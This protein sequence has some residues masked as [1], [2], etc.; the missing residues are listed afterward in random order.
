MPTVKLMEQRWFRIVSSAYCEAVLLFA[1]YFILPWFPS[2][3]AISVIVL[4]WSCVSVFSGLLSRSGR[5][6]IRFC[7]WD[8][9]RRKSRY[10]VRD[11]G[12]GRERMY[13][14]VICLG[15]ICWIHVF[16]FAFPIVIIYSLVYYDSLGDECSMSTFWFKV[17]TLV[18]RYFLST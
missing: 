11:I 3:R 8:E 14:I 4:A 1:T 18:Y 5:L 7:K 10:V 15:F 6:F 12:N 17:G 13:G 2:L 16:I 9:L